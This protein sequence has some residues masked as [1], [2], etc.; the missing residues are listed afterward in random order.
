MQITP[1]SHSRHY[2]TV[3]I[4][5]SAKQLAKKSTSKVNKQ[6]VYAIRCKQV[7]YNGT[8]HRSVNFK[9]SQ[10]DW[11]IEPYNNKY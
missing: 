4:E 1:Q 8:K 7:M 11:R 9:L 5:N 3:Q 2:V 10:G 6:V